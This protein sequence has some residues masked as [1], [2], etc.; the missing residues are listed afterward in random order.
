MRDVSCRQEY[1]QK[2]EFGMMHDGGERELMFAKQQW[3]IFFIMEKQGKSSL[4][5][6][7]D[8][9]VSHKV[10][11]FSKDISLCFTAAIFQTV[12]KETICL[13]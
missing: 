3:R 12:S 6:A 4:P 9:C 8:G 13:Y 1:W 2:A 11:L 10:N 7:A 5:T